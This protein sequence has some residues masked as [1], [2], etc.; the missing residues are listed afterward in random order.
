LEAGKEMIGAF[1]PGGRDKIV[2]TALNRQAANPNEAVTALDSYVAGRDAFPDSV[3]G[4]R[5][6]AGKA[7]RDPGLMAAVEVAEA[8]TPAMKAQYQS[9][10][11][12]LHDAIDRASAGLPPAEMAGETIQKTLRQRFEDL[13]KQRREATDPLYQ[14]ARQSPTP[15]QPWPLMTFTADAVAANKGEPAQVMSKARELLFTTDKNG[16]VIADRSSRGL[17]A[18]RDALNDMLSNTELGNHSRSLLMEMKSKVDDALNAV[19]QAKVANAKFAEMSK[20]LDPFNEKLGNK[21]VA[22]VIEKDQFNKGLLMPA[23]KVPSQFMK[24]GDLSA[25]TIQKLMMASGGDTAVKQAMQSAYL[26]DFRK[27]AAS[28]VAEDPKGGKMLTAS[29]ASKWLE[30][31]S[32]GAANVLTPDQMAALRDITKHLTDQAQTVPGR[33]GSPTFDRLATESIV[34]ALISPKYADAPFLHPVRKTLGLVYGGA[35]EAAMTRL[36][37]ALSDPAVASA[38]MKKATP[39]NVKMASPVLERIAKGSTAPTI[40][41]DER[42]SP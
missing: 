3:P 5:L 4:F 11:T 20:P 42:G 35:N 9:N 8:K 23:E 26:S 22:D 27:A 32:G 39:G 28:A 31:H 2:G 29:G 13:V 41:Q 10:N 17:M 6:D 24:G 38:L 40:R 7:S 34:G 36:V 33:T 30:K 19:P 16:R 15:V 1:T 14:S 37:E 18:T 21:V 25:P 12:K